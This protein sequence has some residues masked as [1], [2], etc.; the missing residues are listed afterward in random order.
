MAKLISY[1][2]AAIGILIIAF[3]SYIQK[4]LPMIPSTP[5]YVLLAG[6]ALVV[7][8]IVFMMG[9]TKLGKQEKEVPIYDK[10][11]KRIVGYRRM[12]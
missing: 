4:A 8:G 2:L 9:G 12:K 10:T 1:I 5:P 3:M 6:V 11:G 7:L